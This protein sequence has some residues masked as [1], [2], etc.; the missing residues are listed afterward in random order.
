MGGRLSADHARQ[1]LVLVSPLIDRYRVSTGAPR[2]GYRR[3][4][5]VLDTWVIV[6]RGG[7]LGELLP[8]RIACSPGNFYELKA[9]HVLRRGQTNLDAIAAARQEGREQFARRL[10]ADGVL[11]VVGDAAADILGEAVSAL[12]RGLAPLAI[13]LAVGLVIYASVKGK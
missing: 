3:L 1:L 7:R 13:P 6:S 5:Q 4:G 8:A 9:V 2:N 11:G 10:E 12:L